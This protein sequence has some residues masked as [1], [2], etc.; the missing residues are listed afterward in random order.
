[1]QFPKYV[2]VGLG[3]MSLAVVQGRAAETDP[4]G[5]EVGRSGAVIGLSLGEGNPF[6]TTE[7]E[8]INARLVE[9]PGSSV[10]LALWEELPP[11]G[12]AVPFYAISLDGENMAR[13]RR[14]SYALKLRHGDFDPLGGVPHVEL[15]LSAGPTTNLYV[16]QF[17]TQPLEEFRA[18]IEALGGTVYNYLANH[19]HIVKMDP[20]TRGKVAAL[21]FVRW[22]GPYHPTY[23]LEEFMRDNIDHAAQFYPS[24]RYNIQVFEAGNEQKNIVAD[25]IQ[26]LGGTVDS[27][28]AGK[29]LLVATLT[30]EQL[31]GVVRW[32]EVMFI[33]RWGPYEE[34]MNNARIIGGADYIESVGGYTGTGVRGEVFDGGFNLIHVDFASRP[35]IIHGG[36][37]TSSHGASTSGIVFG[38]GTGNPIARGMLPDGQG[39][40]ASYSTSCGGPGLTGPSRYDHDGELVGPPYFGVFQTASVGTWPRTTQY[41]TISADTDATLFDFDTVHCQSQSNMGDQMSRPQAW[42]KNIISGGGVRHFDTLDRSN[43]CWCNGA[44]IGPAADGR[45][46]PDLTH[47]YDSIFTTTCC[48]ATS[49]TSGFGGTSGATPII[50]GHVGLFFQMWAD[51][52]FGNTLVD[53]TCDPAT[54]DDCVFKNRSHMTMAKAML[55]NTASQYDWTAG[56]PNADLDRFKQGWGL[57]DLQKMYDLALAEKIFVIDETRVLT[58]LTSALYTLKVPSGEPALKATMTYADP[59]GTTSSTQHRINDLTLKVTSPSGVV[60]WGN[61]GLLTGLWSVAGGSADTIDTVENVFVEN[62]EPGMWNVLVSADE[63]NQDGHVETPGIDADFALVVSGVVE[64][65]IGACCLPNRTCLRTDEADCLARCGTYRGDNTLCL[66]VCEV[67]I[68]ATSSSDSTSEA[69]AE[70]QPIPCKRVCRLHPTEACCFVDG[71]CTDLD[72][73]LCDQQGGIPQGSATTCDLT[74]CPPP[75][76]ACCLEDGTCTITDQATCEGQ[77]G[78]YQGDNSNCNLS[79][80]IVPL[81]ACCFSDATCSEA[82]VCACLQQGGTPKGSST[83][84]NTGACCFRDGRCRQID[85]CMC[86]QSGGNFRGSGTS[87]GPLRCP[88]KYEKK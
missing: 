84:C 17:V 29:Y 4:P 50:C 54:E 5:L 36:A 15:A 74:D 65:A 6:H 75:G 14:T 49:Y 2:L 27:R 80:P 12:Q 68:E 8:V 3:V 83:D 47:F 58:N 37:C 64:D 69:N 21:E 85:L 34:D 9:V 38:D 70:S 59:P 42:A 51:G 20:G 82:T 39:I 60:Y 53:P 44:S 19:A 61:N 56:G 13:V 81:Q 41:T 16:V 63:I 22:V 86:Q 73:C 35:L 24:Q 46:K 57:P 31:F 71:T 18:V 66:A 33:D 88:V 55:I 10:R 76:G 11:G 79:C 30:P 67:E 40:V 48:G 77:C 32:D 45:V 43:D 87:C 28:D 7:R 52:I 1:M 78:T 25:R 62:P 72:D 23:R 26:A